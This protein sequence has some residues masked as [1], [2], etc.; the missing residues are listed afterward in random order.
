M[1]ITR[2]EWTIDYAGLIVNTFYAF[3]WKF[4]QHLMPVGSKYD[5]FAE[6]DYTVNQLPNRS[7]FVSGRAAVTHPDGSAAPDRVAGHYSQDRGVQYA[8]LTT[9][10]AVE[11][12]EMWCCNYLANKN[13]L[14]DLDPVV[15]LAGES[16][17]FKEGQLVFLMKGRSE[18]LEAPRPFVPAEDMTVTADED[19]YAYIISEP[20]E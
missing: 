4:H 8:G 5:M 1:N 6:H 13:A 15:L 20:R 12:C 17:D 7:I 18:E 19:F 9:T 14:P 2:K 16:H 11:P 10:T 3:G